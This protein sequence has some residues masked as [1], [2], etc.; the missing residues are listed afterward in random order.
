MVMKLVPENMNEAIKHLPGRS[1]E[2]LDKYA[3]QFKAYDKKVFAYLKYDH[4]IKKETIRRIYVFTHY[5][6]GKNIIRSNYIDK[7]SPKKAAIEIYKIFYE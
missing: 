3:K 4:N 2:E 5:G 1:Q 7:I 6:Q